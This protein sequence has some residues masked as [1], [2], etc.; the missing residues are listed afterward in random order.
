MLQK[1]ERVCR[2]HRQCER[3]LG[4]KKKQQNYVTTKTKER[5]IINDWKT[6][7]LQLFCL[8][9]NYARDRTRWA[10]CEI[11]FTAPT[12]ICWAKTKNKINKKMKREI[13]WLVQNEKQLRRRTKDVRRWMIIGGTNWWTVMSSERPTATRG[14]RDRSRKLGIIFCRLPAEKSKVKEQKG[15]GCF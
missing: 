7:S 9:S 8:W 1:D 12:T 2:A 10:F 11:E 3:P 14:L 13:K 6:S 5:E 15:E 4:Y